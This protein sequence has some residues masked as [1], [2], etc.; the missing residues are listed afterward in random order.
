MAQDYKIKDITL[1]KWGRAEI[2][3]AEKEMPGLMALRTSRASRG[4]S[5]TP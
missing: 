4:R 5:A 2:T 1:A 3:L